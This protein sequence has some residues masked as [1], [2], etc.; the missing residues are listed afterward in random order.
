MAFIP[1]KQSA[2]IVTLNYPYKADEFLQVV[3][4]KELYSKYFLSDI[5]VNIEI[6]HPNSE[7]VRKEFEFDKPLVGL[8]SEENNIN[9]I[10]TIYEKKLDIVNYDFNP[11]EI[12]VFKTIANE[13]IDPKISDISAIGI[14]FISEFEPGIKLQLLNKEIEK[15]QDFDK[16]LTFQLVLPIQYDGYIATYKVQKLVPEEKS[17]SRRYKIDVNYHIDLAEKTSR[18]KLEILNQNLNNLKNNFYTPY[19]SKCQEFLNL[20]YG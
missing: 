17:M 11:Q 2:T 10:L 12:E 1:I 16:N 3:R 20:N 6:N 9:V 15:I 14:N 7:Q 5:P 19:Y 13:L 18:E 8:K 4:K